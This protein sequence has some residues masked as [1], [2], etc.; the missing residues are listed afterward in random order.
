VGIIPKHAP[1]LGHRLGNRVLR[2]D[3]AGPEVFLQFGSADHAPGMLDQVNQ[4]EH[5]LRFEPNVMAVDRD[6]QARWLNSATSDVENFGPSG[7]SCAQ[8]CHHFVG[9]ADV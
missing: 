7:P 6:L 8:S 5:D 1:Q 9:K 3:S 4:H 2:D